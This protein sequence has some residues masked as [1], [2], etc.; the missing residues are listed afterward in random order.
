MAKSMP[1]AGRPS[2]TA[3]HVQPPR[4]QGVLPGGRKKREIAQDV[5]PSQPQ[6]SGDAPQPQGSPGS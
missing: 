6:P 3:G 1:R 5:Y 2:R 4:G